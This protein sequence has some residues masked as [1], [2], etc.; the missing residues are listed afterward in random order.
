[1]AWYPE[2]ATWVGWED[3]DHGAWTD[4]SLAAI[5]RRHARL[6]DPLAV[7]ESIPR[8]A[9]SPEDRLSYD[10]FRR[11]LELEVEGTRFPDHLMPITQ[12]DGIHQE[13]ANLLAA[14]PART[15][16]DFEA[17]LSR[18]HGLPERIEQTVALMEAG[19]EAGVVQPRVPLRDVPDQ[20]AALIVE[21]PLESPMLQAFRERPASIPEETWG[22]LRMDAVDAYEQGIAPALER[23]RR[24]LDEAYLP[25]SRRAIAA[26]ELPDGEAWYAYRVRRSTTTDL[27]PREIHELG[28]AEVAR[29]RSEMEA[30]I[31][32]TAESRAADPD[33]PDGDDFAAF[34]EWLRTD[35]RFYHDDPEALLTGYR[36]IQALKR[37]DPELAALFGTLPRLPY[38]VKAVPAFA[39]KSQTTAYYRRGSAEAG[40]PGWFFANT[41]ALDTRPKWEMEALTLHEA[42]PGHHL[43][44]ARAQEL[45]DLPRF[46]RFT[47]PT[48]FVE[49]WGLYAESLGEEMGFYEDPYSKFGQLTYEMWRA[50]RLVVD[51][52]MHAFGWDRQ[53]AIDFF[54][55][56]S[57]KPLHDITVEIDRYI[58]WPA[59]ALAYKIG[60]LRIK[61]LRAR[62]EEAL[63]DD[64]DIREFHDVVLGAGALP[65]DLLEGRVEAWIAERGATPAAD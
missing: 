32:A 10:L 41:Y 39:E 30:I 61:A 35:P 20:V 59:Q 15:E 2:W 54:A 37:A 38:G 29:I 53:R 26:T 22:R 31:A 46:R 56:N 18:L 24:F 45:E 40:R 7:L 25:G 44:I 21:D 50:V 28:L 5:E 36:D 11:D 58:V 42:V 62:A 55:A 64:F 60:E 51:T 47:G 9:L 27:S 63:G 8:D 3:A 43:Q 49:G 19:L 17:I 4:A 1:M 13:A 48:A 6:G 57:S 16:D 34:T 14:M 12:L 65:L 52:G 23:L 33:A